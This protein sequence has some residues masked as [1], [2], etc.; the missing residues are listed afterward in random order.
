MNQLQSKSPGKKTTKKKVAT[1][2]IP[3]KPRPYQ[4]DVHNALKRFSVLVCHRRF[5]KSVLAINELIKTAADKPRSLCAFIAPT[6][7]QGKAIAW[8]YL[9]IYTKPLMYLGGSKNET[10][11]KIELFNGSTLQIFGLVSYMLHAIVCLLR[12]PH[13]PFNSPGKPYLPP[14]LKQQAPHPEHRKL[15]IT[16]YLQNPHPRPLYCN[17]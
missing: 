8:E 14:T 2:E 6:Y 9:K 17:P 15:L 11:L 10:E 7:R 12:F 13:G 4:Q 1:V 16:K 3:Y 5:G